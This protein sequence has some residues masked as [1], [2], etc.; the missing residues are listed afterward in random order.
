MQNS[1]LI[2]PKAKGRR[3]IV[4]KFNK[5]NPPLYLSPVFAGEML[6]VK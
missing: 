2:S 4:L 1:F 6:N 5:I 3:E